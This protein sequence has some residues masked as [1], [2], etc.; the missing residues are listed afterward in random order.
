MRGWVICHLRARTKWFAE[1]PRHPR[2]GTTDRHVPLRATRSDYSGG[3]HRVLDTFGYDVVRAIVPQLISIH[4]S[5]RRGGERGRVATSAGLAP[6]TTSEEISK[7]SSR[8][9][10]YVVSKLRPSSKRIAEKMSP[11]NAARPPSQ[12]SSRPWRRCKNLEK[13]RFTKKAFFST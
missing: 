13:A 5:E 7:L 12:L 1:C 10:E 8:K 9:P 2:T 3:K 6:K 4:P 11:A